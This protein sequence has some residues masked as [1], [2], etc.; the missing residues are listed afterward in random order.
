MSDKLG[1][2]LGG[3]RNL[4]SQLLESLA[5]RLWNQQCRCDTEQHE[6]GEN[7]D[8]V[9]EPWRGIGLGCA[10]NAEGTDE[11][12][13]DNGTDLARGGRDTVRGGSVAGW[14]ALARN[15][16]GCRVGACVWSDA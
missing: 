13:G 12:L 6:E 10:A 5:L 11:G 14:E 2:V 15:N 3:T 16:K 4:A 7:L 1:V 9:V 8:D